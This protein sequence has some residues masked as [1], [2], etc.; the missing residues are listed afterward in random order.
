MTRRE[1]RENVFKLLFRLEFNSQDEMPEQV[2]LYFEGHEELGEK[3]QQYIEEKY[4]AILSR[5]DEIDKDIEAV[6]EGWKL[7]RMGKVDLTLIRLAAYEMKY[8]PT[9]PTGVAINEAVEISKIFGGD[10]S[11]AFINGILAKL[12]PSE[13][14]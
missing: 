14:V 10:E 5:L 13:T 6:S 11:P 9:V 7:S 1:L 4:N 12:V 3:D 8:D 2:K